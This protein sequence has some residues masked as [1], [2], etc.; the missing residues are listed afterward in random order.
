MET[1]LDPAS[2]DDICVGTDMCSTFHQITCLYI[3]GRTC[4]G[5]C[6]P[7]SPLYL[8][9]AAALAAG[10]PDSV[11]VSTV[12][13]LCSS[14]LMAIRS[15]A[16]SIRAGEISLGLAVGVESMSVKSVLVA[17]SCSLIL[18]RFLYL[19]RLHSPRPTPVVVDAVGA[20]PQAHD[21]I[22]VRLLGVAA[23]GW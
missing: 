20:N 8:S 15:I 23:Y 13:R 6:H 17:F 1:T 3:M 2:I 12:N 9:R 22:Q 5:T 7:P 18:R 16:H 14:G 10:I 19:S 4:E 11:P 21:C